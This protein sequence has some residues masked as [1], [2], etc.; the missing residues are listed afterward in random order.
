MDQSTAKKELQELIKNEELKNKT[1]VDC[2]N[3]N[4][5][6]ASLRCDIGLFLTMCL[7]NTNC[8]HAVTQSFSVCNVLVFTE[9]LVSMLGKSL[10]TF[11][12][13]S[14]SSKFCSSFVRSVS[15]DSWQEDQIRRMKVR[16]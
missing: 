5:Q 2:A 11:L 6:W 3:P 4:P 8:F 15:M 14:G 10:I 7:Y 1:C 12:F 13:N 16:E 9:V